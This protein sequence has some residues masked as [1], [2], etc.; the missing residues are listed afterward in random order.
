MLPDCH[1]RGV[2]A[3][4]DVVPVTQTGAVSGATGVDHHRRLHVTHTTAP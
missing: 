2:L 3:R 4:L 1:P